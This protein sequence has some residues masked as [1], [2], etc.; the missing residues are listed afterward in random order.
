MQQLID[1]GKAFVSNWRIYTGT[2]DLWMDAI[3][4][5]MVSQH[6]INCLPA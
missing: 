6:Y 3:V 4:Q 5:T 1:S 2:I